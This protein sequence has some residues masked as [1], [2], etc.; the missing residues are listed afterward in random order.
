MCH[1]YILE[2][3]KANIIINSYILHL[4]INYDI[5]I[6]AITRLNYKI[7]YIQQWNNY[8][9]KR[10][11]RL[12]DSH[13]IPF[14]KSGRAARRSPVLICFPLFIGTL[15]VLMIR[16]KK[17]TVMP[18]PTKA[19]LPRPGK[20]TAFAS[21][22]QPNPINPGYFNPNGLLPSSCIPT[23]SSSSSIYPILC[24]IIRCLWL[25]LN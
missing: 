6:I 14:K 20:S 5:I 16:G 22:N 10:D 12:K 1:K 15:I 7:Y 24:H 2:K 19:F 13:E 18:K 21:H 23:S 17:N 11:R 3:F 4:L 25:C 9:V 8:Q